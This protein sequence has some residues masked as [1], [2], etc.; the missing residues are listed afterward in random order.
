M[1][2]P[3]QCNGCIFAF[4]AKLPDGCTTVMAPEGG[5]KEELRMGKGGK[6][7]LTVCFNNRL[8]AGGTSLPT[9]WSTL[10]VSSTL[11]PLMIK[12]L[13]VPQSRI[14]IFASYTSANG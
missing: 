7:G 14:I 1:Q 10:I 4:G 8:S 9:L 6:G 12:M 13:K 5:E 2:A 3:L 11:P